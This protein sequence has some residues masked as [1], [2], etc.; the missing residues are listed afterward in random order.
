M[1]HT[2]KEKEVILKKAIKVAKDNNLIFIDD[3]SAFLPVTSRTFYDWRFHKSQELKEILDDNKVIV[4][5]NLR[6][7]WETLD[8]PTLNIALYKLVAN[9]EERKI[10]ADNQTIK[11]ED[12][13]DIV[14]KVKK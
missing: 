4:K 14:I 6:K 12:M 10:L 9:E 3:V 1:A 5:V 7:K 2:K 8:N 13:P 11:L